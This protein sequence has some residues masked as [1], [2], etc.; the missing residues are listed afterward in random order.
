MAT[1]AKDMDRWIEKRD[2]LSRKMEDIR[3][4]KNSALKREVSKYFD[5][6]NAVESRD[7]APPVHTRSW[8]KVG[9]ELMRGIVAFP[10]DDHYRPLN[11]T[12]MHNLCSLSDCLV[13]RTQ[14]SKA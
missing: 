2:E 13:V 1:L 7:H 10:C 5:S 8:A 11:A 12:W 9:R 4:Q 3:K 6:S 14:E